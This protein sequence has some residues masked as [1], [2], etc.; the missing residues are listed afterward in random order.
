VALCLELA[1]ACTAAARSLAVAARLP[2]GRA[3]WQT[4]YESANSGLRQAP[5]W[6]QVWLHAVPA[7]AAPWVVLAITSPSAFTFNVVAACVF[8][9][10]SL[11]KAWAYLWSPSAQKNPGIVAAQVLSSAV[12][13]EG[14][15][16][17]G[18]FI[19]SSRV[20][21]AF[22]SI[23]TRIDSAYFA[24]STATTTGLGDIHPVTQAARLLV[25]GQMVV[26]LFLVVIA[27]GT[28]LTRLLNRPSQS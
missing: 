13:I 27:V 7:A 2:A 22:N 5:P 16:A 8:V 15:F 23:L 10:Y 21:D 19:L 24:V 28:A 4:A 9:F 3:L 1:A 11:L 17:L 14:C 20:P 26:S 12:A 25:T 6:A 18:Y